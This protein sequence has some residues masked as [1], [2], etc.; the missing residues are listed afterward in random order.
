MATYKVLVTGITGFVGS[1]LARQLIESGNEVVGLLHNHSDRQKPKRLKDMDIVSDISFVRGDVTDLTSVLSAIQYAEPDWIFHLAAQSDVPTSFKDP[2]STFRTNCLGTQNILE[3]IRL[4]NSESRIIFAGSS[5]E[6]GLQF[7]DK[8]H[9]EEMKKRYSI[10][11][12]MPKVFP[13]IPLDEESSLRPMSPYATSKVYGDYACR[14][15]NNTYNINTIVSRAFNHE[16][17]GRGDNFVT[18]TIIRQLVAMHLEQQNVMTI[19]NI[20]AFRDWS[21][22]EDMVNGYVLLADNADAGS[23]YVQGSMRTISVLSYI[24]YSIS[25]LGYEINEIHSIN[26]EQKK[27]KDPLKKTEA[28]I[29]G[30][31]INSN[32]VDEMFLS[33][34][35][36]FNLADKGLIIKTDKQ[37][38]KVQFDPSKFRRSDVPI[39]LANANKIKQLG[40]FSKKNLTHIINDQINYYLNPDNR[41]IITDML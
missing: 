29:G 28:E 41:D 23:V 16:G 5:E 32:A 4:K 27:V 15:Y 18:S 19:G 1:Y 22:V 12:P 7:I 17:A 30:I 36:Q 35:L 14:N 24:L 6:Y 26:N 8:N 13:E 10:I 38:F 21:H 34:S 2:L 31:R 3:G 39:L 20:Q 11:E 33:Y 25:Q 37:D 40:F 9:Y